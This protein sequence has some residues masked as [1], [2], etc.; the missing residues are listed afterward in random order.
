M[1]QSYLHKRVTHHH[2]QID[3]D[4][5]VEELGKE[6]IY[7]YLRVHEGCRIQHAK[8][9]EKIRKEHHRRI[10]LGTKSEFNSTNQMKAIKTQYPL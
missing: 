5:T 1:C 6:D 10:K 4:T 9:K 7:K 3:L 8:L 2:I